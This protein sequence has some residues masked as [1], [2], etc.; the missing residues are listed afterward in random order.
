MNTVATEHLPLSAEDFTALEVWLSV[1]RQSFP[2]TPDWEF[3]EGFMAALICS[4]FSTGR[5]SAAS[6]SCSALYS[7][8]LSASSLRA[9]R[10]VRLPMIA[11]VASTPTSAVSRR[12][13]RS[14]SRSSS[15]AFLPRN[16][17]AIPSPRLALVFDRPCLR[18]SR[19]PAR[20]SSALLLSTTGSAGA[21]TGAT[22]SGW[23]SG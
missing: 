13:S 15:M 17:L 5:S 21:T 23:G 11:V 3:C 4:G 8:P 1:R 14:S 22:G 16:R 7:A 10:L 18:R 20:V 6:S 12:V 19:K 9:T 2:E